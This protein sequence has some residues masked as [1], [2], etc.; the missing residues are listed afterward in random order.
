[1]N[2][3]FTT[4]FLVD[5][6]P[7]KVFAAIND[8]RSWWSGNVRAAPTNSA[9]S[10]RIATKT[11]IIRNS[12][13]PSSS[14][15]KRSFGTCSTAG[16]ISSQTN[17]SGRV[18]ESCSTSLH[19]ATRPRLRSRRGLA[20]EPMFHRV[21]ER[22]ELLHQRKFA[23]LDCRRCMMDILHRVGITS[24]LKMSIRRWRRATALPLGGRPTR[25]GR[26][27]SAALSSSVF[28]RAA[29]T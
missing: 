25:K 26:A 14:P 9:T 15:T 13:S 11:S 24:S 1:M 4:S 5:Q 16:S 22:V 29:S 10:L 2:Q 3:D 6:G 8:V 7:Q 23:A 20:R 17:V 28:R 27:P 12:G 18:Q 21:F 19:E